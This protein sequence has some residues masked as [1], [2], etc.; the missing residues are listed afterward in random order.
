MHYETRFGSLGS[1]EKGGVEPISDDPKNYVFSNIFEVA[2]TQPAWSRVCVAKN[3]EYIV[4]ACRT[5]GTSPY[6]A[7]GH[8]EFLLCM[9]G[10]VQVELH[11]L[12][13]PESVIEADR[14]GAH[15]L[16]DLPPAQRMGRVVLRR[17]HM[18]LLPAGAAY[19]LESASPGAVIFQTIEGP[20]TT[21]KWAEICQTK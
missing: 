8:D 20:D 9:D 18:A 21:F 15:R 13:D 14:D 4:E 10:E 7:A 5:D 6:W 2:S 1:F 12:D 19:R 3:F 17:G 16:K 11:K